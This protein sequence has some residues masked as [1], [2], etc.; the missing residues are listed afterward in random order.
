MTTLTVALIAIDTQRVA[1]QDAIAALTP[2]YTVGFLRPCCSASEPNPTC[3]TLPTHWYA[4][5][6]KCPSDVV[7]AW[8]DAVT[9]AEGGNALFDLKIFTAQNALDATMWAA[10][11]LSSE[12]L[13]FVP[14]PT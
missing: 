5:G 13:Q 10:S 12:G 7:Q 4:N 11:N 9:G 6:A 3:D 2:N 1:V 14:D 8:Q